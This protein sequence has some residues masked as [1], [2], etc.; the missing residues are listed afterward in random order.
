[1]ARYMKK[2]YTFSDGTFVPRGTYIGASAYSTHM[3]EKTYPDPEQFDP[4]RYS[5]MRE[6][7]E[8]EV[9]KHQMVATSPDYLTFGLG[10]HAW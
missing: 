5:E 9:T 6:E 7:D 4:F 10:K 1:M 8:K 3:E 2:D